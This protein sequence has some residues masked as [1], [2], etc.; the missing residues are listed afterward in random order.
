M[1]DDRLR[2]AWRKDEALLAKIG[3]ALAPQET[4]VEVRVPRELADAAV[5]AW[6]RTDD[7]SLA[8][9]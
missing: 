7:G 5:L 6:R 8:T 3:G 4:E 9:P 1:D 2:S